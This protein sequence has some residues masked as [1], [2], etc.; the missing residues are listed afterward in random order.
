M[1]YHIVFYCIV[2]YCIVLYC[3]VLYYFRPAPAPSCPMYLQGAY[4]GD[5]GTYWSDEGLTKFGEITKIKVRSGG[6]VDG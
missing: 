3:I 6:E 4:G 2:F 5:G 1:L